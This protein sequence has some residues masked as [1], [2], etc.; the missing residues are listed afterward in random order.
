MK[1]SMLLI[2]TGIFWVNYAFCQ[3][4]IKVFGSE[5]PLAVKNQIV[6]YLH[7]LDVQENIYLSVTFTADIPE[8]YKGITFCADSVRF[9]KHH[10]YQII[11]VRISLHQSAINQMKV[12]AH[13]MIH[14][15]QY[16]KG[17][18]VV[19]SHQQVLWKGRNYSYQ[20]DNHQHVPWER[21]AYKNDNL[22]AKH[23]KL[24]TEIPQ[25]ALVKIP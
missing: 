14:V 8:E 2:L 23:F 7:H 20:R 5:D 15:K 10:G 19:L 4:I 16:A 11:K 21:E 6:Q 12:L 24:Q 18:L 22:L 17:E 13:E 1:Q 3:P 25:V 9:T